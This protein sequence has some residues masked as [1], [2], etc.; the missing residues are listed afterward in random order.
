LGTARSDDE[1]HDI[2]Q[3]RSDGE[4]DPDAYRILGKHL[5]KHPLSVIVLAAGGDRPAKVQGREAGRKTSLYGMA[6]D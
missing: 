5:A 6:R 4:F 2:A 3:L 1:V